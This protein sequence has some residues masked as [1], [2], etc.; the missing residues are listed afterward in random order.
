[1][2]KKEPLALI[3][4][5]SVAFVGCGRKKD[6]STSRKADLPPPPQSE[7]LPAPAELVPVPPDAVQA[8]M[9]SSSVAEAVKAVQAGTAS[10]E[11]QQVVREKLLD[12]E[13]RHGRP[14]SSLT[15]LLKTNAATRPAKK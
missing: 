14:V 2:M 5:I 10:P 7:S 3:L 1:M 6:D 9:A 11:Q 8:V 4:A 12:F 15:D 13:M